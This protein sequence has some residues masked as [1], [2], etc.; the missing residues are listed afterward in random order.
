M[1][2]FRAQSESE[3]R[4]DKHTNRDNLLNMY[5]YMYVHFA[6]VSYRHEHYFF[7]ANDISHMKEP[8]IPDT[9]LNHRVYLSRS[10]ST[11]RYSRKC[12]YFPFQSRRTVSSG[13]SRE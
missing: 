4:K 13:Q 1:K 12:V 2:C 3:T 11:A 7:T 8:N 10:L 6:R 5:T 9:I